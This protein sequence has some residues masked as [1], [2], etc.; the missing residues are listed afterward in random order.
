MAGIL[1]PSSTI[2]NYPAAIMNEQEQRDLAARIILDAMGVCIEKNV[3]A[4]VVNLVTLSAAV[5]QFVTHFGEEATATILESL[6][7]KVRAGA[8]SHPSATGRA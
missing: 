1:G 8:F 3:S 7:E 2:R 6:P 5:T 4:E